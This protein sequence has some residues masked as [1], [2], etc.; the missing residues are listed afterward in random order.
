MVEYTVRGKSIQ[1]LGMQM[2]H[3]V[4]YLIVKPKWKRERTSSSMA[5][6]TFNHQFIWLRLCH[7]S[8]RTPITDATLQS[9]N[10]ICHFRPSNSLILPFAIYLSQSL[11]TSANSSQRVNSAEVKRKVVKNSWVWNLE[12]WVVLPAESGD[13][14]GYLL[15]TFTFSHGT[16]LQSELSFIFPLQ[17]GF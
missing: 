4:L 1:F 3:A 15:C 11:P 2:F 13:A 10:P 7:S 12:I 6:S 17:K 8:R 16:S 14:N 9:T 5:F